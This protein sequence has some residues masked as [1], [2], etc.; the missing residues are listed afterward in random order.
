[1]KAFVFPGQGAQF[2][3]MGKELLT[4]SLAQKRFEQADDLLKYSL[5]KLMFEGPE[6]V[7]RQTEFTQS[8]IFVHSVILAELF[9]DRFQPDAV[10]GHSLGEFSALVAAGYLSFE[11][12]LILVHQRAHAMSGAN[13]NRSMAMVAIL[14]LEDQFIETV[15]KEIMQANPEE[16]VVP[17][18][19]NTQGQVVI[20]GTQLGI[21][22]AVAKLQAQG[23]RKAVPLAVSGA[24]HSPC[25]LSAQEKLAQALAKAEFK[26]G[27]CP[28][29]QNVTA[30]STKDLTEIQKNLLIQLTAPVRWTQIMQNML[31]DGVQEIIEVG[32]GKVLQ[33][34]FKKIDRNLKTSSI[35]E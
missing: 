31:K 26:V 15:C 5:T 4:A 24:F 35:G 33:G 28:I 3:G 30:T 7:L 8:A 25:M 11:E 22:L 21:D 13:A 29:Y 2:V 20:S 10:A 9:A 12:G 1:M 16:I 17:A 6:E 23:L 18:N 19:Y 34:L 27:I 14:G 32:P